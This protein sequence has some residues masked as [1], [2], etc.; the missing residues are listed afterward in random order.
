MACGCGSS[1]NSV[2]HSY[3]GIFYFEED[4][5]RQ[6]LIIYEIRDNIGSKLV[7][8][9]NGNNYMAGGNIKYVLAK[10]EDVYVFSTINRFKRRDDLQM[11][12]EER[13]L[14]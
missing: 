4:E 10:P 13:K 6:D 1:K 8:N 11:N 14:I 2:Y 3:S 7:Y 5:N 12:W 9:V